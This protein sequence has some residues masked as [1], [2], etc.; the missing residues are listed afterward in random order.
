M[1][2]IAVV[3]S[4]AMASTAKARSA[5][6]GGGAAD[7]GGSGPPE[8]E[9]ALLLRLEELRRQIK[10]V[11]ARNAELQATVAEQIATEEA[12]IGNLDG[13][14][15]RNFEHMTAIGSA[16]RELAAAQVAKETNIRLQ[17]EEL[18]KDALFSQERCLDFAKMIELRE[19]ALIEAVTFE[20][21]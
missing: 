19:K 13:K 14:L 6:R 10:A 5:K 1:S 20:E 21:G 8:H 11:T 3:A 15:R 16:K 18:E 9:H 7:E 4:V 17:V 12:V 2:A